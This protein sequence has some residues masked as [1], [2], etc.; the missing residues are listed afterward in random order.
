MS[1]LYLSRARLDPTHD[2]L[3][4]ILFPDDPS[5]RVSVSHRLVWSLFP[6]TLTERP[7]LYRE[8]AP[9]HAGGRAARGDFH[10][11]ST[12]PPGDGGGLFSIETRPFAPDLRRGDRLRFVLRANPTAQR[13]DTRPD[14]RRRSV[15][16][17]VVMRALH[18]V[19][20]GE[21]RIVARP[22]I[23]RSAGLD[24]LVAQ[25]ERAGF[26][27]PDPEAVVIDGYEQILVDPEGRRGGRRAVHSRLDYSGEL[28]VTDPVTFLDQLSRGFGRARAFGNG[29]MLIRRA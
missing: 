5:Q 21:A 10:V 2:R 4:P 25:G 6:E 22:Q 8:A 1:E 13:S 19:A 28:A 3:G 27:V 29:L 11:L 12:I 24:W 26:V 23:I 14:G 15:R 17:D 16:Y 9:A 18:D 20:K 7:F